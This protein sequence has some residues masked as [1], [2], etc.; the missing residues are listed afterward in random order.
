[1]IEGASR[2]CFG[3]S[4][5]KLVDFVRRVPDEPERLK[6][7]RAVDAEEASVVDGVKECSIWDVEPRAPDGCGADDQPGDV[8]L[9]RAHGLLADDFARAVYRRGAVVVIG[10]R[11]IADA[12]DESRRE[13]DHAVNRRRRR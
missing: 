6:D 2:N 7:S 8:E 3:G 11:L 5:E 4:G 1:E 13:E 12:A 9:G 10:N